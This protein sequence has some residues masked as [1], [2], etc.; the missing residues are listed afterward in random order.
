M[1]VVDFT[2]LLHPILLAH[3]ERLVTGDAAVDGAS[4]DGALRKAIRAG[5]ATP[6]SVM[7]SSVEHPGVICVVVYL[8]VMVN[9]RRLA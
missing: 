8:I 4:A 2:N 6:G 1:I 7:V 9:V 5:L 3:V